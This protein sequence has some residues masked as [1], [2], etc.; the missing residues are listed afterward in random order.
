MQYLGGKSKI[1]KQVAS[2]IESYRNPGQEYF[3][4]FVGGGWVLQEVTGKRTAADGNAALISLYVALQNGWEPPDFVSEEEWRFWRESADM[5]NPMKAFCGFGCSFGGK[6]FGGYARSDEKSCYAA[7]SKRSLLKQLPLI[8]DVT[9]LH[10]DFTD[11]TPEG[12]LIY[13]DHPYAGTTNYG[14]F[15]GFD[16]D[17]FWDTMRRWSERN[18]VLISEY[19]APEDFTCVAEFGSRMGLTTNGERPVRTER[20]FTRLS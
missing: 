5:N 18:T 8:R 12:M 10:G 11:W 6:W 1:R 19:S 4:P 2:V 3:E 14:A 20:M 13:C 17:L 7:T 9:F 16:T 15:D